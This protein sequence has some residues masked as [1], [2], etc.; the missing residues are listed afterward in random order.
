M[1]DQ[2]MSKY[3]PAEEEAQMKKVRLLT[4]RGYAI[5]LFIET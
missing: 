2:N 5:D 4:S 1:A 3:Y